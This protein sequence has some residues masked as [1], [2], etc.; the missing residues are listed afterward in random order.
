MTEITQEEIERKILSYLGRAGQVK[1]R[2]VFKALGID[3][4]LVDQAI[5]KL[6][7]EDRVEYIYL[8]TSYV[9]IKE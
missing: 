3:K 8:D 9:K 6:A 7:K 4:K 5:V 1:V 2:S